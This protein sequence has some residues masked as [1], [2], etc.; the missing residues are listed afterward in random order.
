M[1]DLVYAKVIGRF[2]LTVGDTN[3]DV[4]D[5]PDTIW[6]DEGTVRFTPL[7]TFT[8]VAGA[9]PVPFTAG[10]AVIDASIDSEGYLTYLGKRWV[11]LVDLTSD[12]VNPQVGANKATH[13][14]TFI[15]VKA[16]GTLVEF[17]SFNARLTADGPD[18]DGVN[19][20]TK[21]APVVPGSSTPIYRGEAGPSVE[22]AEIVGGELVLVRSDGVELNA[23]ELPVG[24]G[25]SD[26]GVA[27]YINTPGSATETALKATIE[28]VNGE[29]V[30]PL[31][32]ATLADD[33][34]VALAAAT[35]VD[36]E[37]ASRDLV[38]RDDPGIPAELPPSGYMRAWA[39]EN[40]RT[41]LG[42]RPDG[43][44]HA[45]VLDTAQATISTLNE[46]EYSA[47]EAAITG[48]V[49]AV[50][51]QNDRV[52]FGI[53]ADGTVY[54][55]VLESASVAAVA[56]TFR[57]TYNPS[58]APVVSGPN[59]L[60]VGH[61]MLAGAAAAI[62]AAFSPLVVTSL[63]VG[64]ETSRAIA[65][66]Q[67]GQPA[68]FV[69]PGGQ[70]PATT[71][72]VTVT[73]EYADGGTAWPLL[74]GP[75][76]YTGYVVLADGTKVPGTFSVVRDPGATPSTHHAGDVYKFTRTT[77][78]STITCD[79][80]VPF[81][82]DTADAHRDDITIY[83]AGRN[84][85]A[86]TDQVIADLQAMILRQRPLRSRFL[87]LAEHNQATEYAGGPGA[88]AYA[89]IGTLNARLR[90][91]FGR[92]FIDGRRYLID[93]G[94]ADAGITT[95]TGQDTIDISRDVVPESLRGVGDALH[96]N[97][98]GSNVITNLCKRRALE[99]GWIGAA[100]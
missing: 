52:V 90:A 81:Y 50:I 6:C 77:A 95:P 37:L 89:A 67:G 96:L 69:F 45:P 65:A 55:P 10:H 44:V 26:A 76:T 12:L 38:E 32:V 63:A 54:A 28:V 8:K 35:A 99:L 25:G 5:D 22:S 83:W 23:G 73:L 41:I 51:D 3:A 30:P 33:D 60:L 93:Y 24:P 59:V 79:R 27:G 68:R 53:R 47:S 34:T 64:G 88:T 70:I 18:G 13:K 75:A 2:A 72:A 36:G 43:T 14:V 71:T 98:A 17:P 49:R 61:S 48:F 87:V 21:V 39:D 4:D 16:N 11:H 92:R 56:E 86:E 82:Y 19:D 84:N 31:V 94:L 62:S 42:I 9:D 58:Q 74:Q 80:P 66:R 100:S 1:P 20:L 85:Y 91:L 29:Q 97:T 7:T 15:G 78:G 46:V 57:S 40:G